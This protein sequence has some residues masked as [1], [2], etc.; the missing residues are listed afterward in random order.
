MCIGPIPKPIDR[1]TW[2]SL[3]QKG[4]PEAAYP[5]P[6]NMSNLGDALEKDGRQNVIEWPALRREKHAG[7]QRPRGEVEGM[8]GG[9][10]HAERQRARGEAEATRRG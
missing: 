10:G 4:S 5:A 9:R 1:P 6:P 7:R 8:R 3:R 2:T